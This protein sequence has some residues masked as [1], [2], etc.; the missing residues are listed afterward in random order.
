MNG[1]IVGD[2]LLTIEDENNSTAITPDDGDETTVVSTTLN[3][4]NSTDKENE[5]PELPEQVREM[6]EVSME[7]I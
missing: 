1:T 2:G 3:R 6:I 5:T 4:S 7:T